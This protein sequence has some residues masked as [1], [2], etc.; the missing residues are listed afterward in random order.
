M[1]ASDLSLATIQSLKELTNL[2]PLG[3]PGST[4]INTPFSLSL[5]HKASIII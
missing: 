4:K 5:Y 3:E 2:K 1:E